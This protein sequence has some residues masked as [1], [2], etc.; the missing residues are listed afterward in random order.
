ML[1]LGLCILCNVLLAVVFKGFSQYKVNN[2]NAIVINYAVCVTVASIAIGEFAIPAELFSKPWFPFALMLAILFITGFNVLALAFQKCGVALT[3]IIQKMSLI[4]PVVFAVSLYG[5]TL[6][7]LKIVGIVSALGAIVLVNYPTKEMQQDFPRAW[8]I[9]PILAFLM[10]GLIE[11]DLYYVEAE[12]L[13]GEDGLKFT[14]SAFG[15]AGVLGLL[16]TIYKSLR[17]QGFFKKKE[18]IGGLLLG[19]PNFLTIYLLV[20][21]LQMGWEGSVLFPVNSIGILLLT[22]VVGIIAYKESV[23]QLK[24]GGLVLATLAIVLVGL[25]QM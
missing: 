17:G 15:M 13:V 10:S 12:K 7:W 9:F 24:L 1:I 8:L 22:A 3:I 4:I 14:A 23:N 18:L 19:L 11:I 21:L 2:H 25:S 5:E 20:V 16:F 6:G